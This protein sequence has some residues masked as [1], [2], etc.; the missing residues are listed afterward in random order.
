MQLQCPS[1][2]WRLLGKSY[3]HVFVEVHI[4]FQVVRQQTEKSER[5]IEFTS[6]VNDLKICLWPEHTFAEL[7]L[8]AVVPKRCDSDSFIITSLMFVSKQVVEHRN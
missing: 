7:I 2:L 5:K 1:L 6:R 8:C 3:L 4:L